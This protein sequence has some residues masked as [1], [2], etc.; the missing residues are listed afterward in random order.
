M[1]DLSKSG[2]PSLSTTLPCAAHRPSGAS[3]GE[4]LA[5]GDALYMTSSGTL[6]K[7]GGGTIL[8]QPN[9]PDVSF[10]TSGGTV[11]AGS[12]LVRTTYIDDSGNE[13]IVSLPTQVKPT[14]TTATI[15]VKSP[16]ASTGATKYKVY[17]SDINGNVLYLQNSTGTALAS[18]FTLS[19]PPATNTA[20]PPT[21]AAAYPSLQFVGLCA[22]AVSKSGEAATPIHG[23]CF[24]YGSGLTPGTRYY[25]ST[26]TAGRLATTP[27][28]D[29]APA[30]AYAFDS[31]RIFVFP[32]TR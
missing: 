14:G 22:A 18:D 31:S 23:V 3:A 9:V 21:V 4:D 30:V 11:Q 24:A 19:A 8:A 17:I 27:P 5:G 10:T 25:L 28:Y 13:S 7:T 12:Y 6:K 1:S 20:N 32:V 16:P 26:A 2:T 29:G 15:T